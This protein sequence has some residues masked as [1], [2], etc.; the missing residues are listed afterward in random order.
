MTG[1]IAIRMKYMYMY[2]YVYVYVYVHVYVYVYCICICMCI[3]IGI[4]I[5]K[6]IYIYMYPPTL[7]RVERLGAKGYPLTPWE[8]Q[9]GHVTLRERSVNVPLTLR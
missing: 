6:G 5:G 4:G 7:G 2:V 9:S 3:R 8:D 1:H